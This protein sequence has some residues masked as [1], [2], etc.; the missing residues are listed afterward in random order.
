MAASPA[1]RA[2]FHR[3]PAA[4]EPAVRRVAIHTVPFT[5]TTQLNAMISGTPRQAGPSVAP[6]SYSPNTRPVATPTASAANVS[7]Q[8]PASHVKNRTP[9][10]AAEGT[11]ASTAVASRNPGVIRSIHGS[12]GA[13]T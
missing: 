4:G 7:A 12:V 5:T 3:R 6:Y 10:Y 8:A 2:I 9:P 11:V 1:H 13:M